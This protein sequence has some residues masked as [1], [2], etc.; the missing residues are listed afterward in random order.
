[1][2]RSRACSAQRTNR[3]C[4][5]RFLSHHA[6]ICCSRC[7]V[8]NAG[9]SERYSFFSQSRRQILYLCPPLKN[10]GRGRNRC[11]AMRVPYPMLAIIASKSQ[12]A[13]FSRQR[14]TVIGPK[15]ADVIG[16][17]FS[18]SQGG[19]I[20]GT[21]KK[22]HQAT[23]VRTTALLFNSCTFVYMRTNRSHGVLRLGSFRCC[24]THA[25]HS[26]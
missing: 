9:C 7:S 25:L 14:G 3:W 19:K 23:E 24:F 16:L 1:M 8:P 17:S 10:S 4:F 22:M 2:S 6:M 26:S 20:R 15:S 21:G 13:L 11:L 12:I 5:T 18:L